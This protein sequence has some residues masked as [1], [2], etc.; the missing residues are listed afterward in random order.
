MAQRW[1]S[2]TCRNFPGCVEDDDGRCCL[3]SYLKRGRCR[4]TTY[5]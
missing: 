3:P 2:G 1:N 4:R 5:N